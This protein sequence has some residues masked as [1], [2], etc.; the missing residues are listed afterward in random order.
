[1]NTLLWIQFCTPFHFSLSTYMFIWLSF[2]YSVNS[3]Y[4]VHIITRKKGIY[5]LYNYYIYVNTNKK[6]QNPVN[7]LPSFFLM[8]AVYQVSVPWSEMLHFSLQHYELKR[9]CFQT[10]HALSQLGHAASHAV[11]SRGSDYPVSIWWIRFFFL[12][13]RFICESLVIPFF[14]SLMVSWQ[15]WNTSH[16]E[17]E[18]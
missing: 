11:D 18:S 6:S 14:H 10:T 17:S 13:K 12:L 8:A 15:I 3:V 1:M 7:D 5:I 4:S 16:V 9:S 2:V